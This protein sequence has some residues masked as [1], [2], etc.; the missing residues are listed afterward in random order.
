MHSGL[1][2]GFGIVFFAINIFTRFHEMCWD[3][4]LLGQ[5]FLVGGMFLLVIGAC[6]EVSVRMLRKI[7]DASEP[8]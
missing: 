6:A 1:L 7:G 5:Y 4:L 3:R 2:R 8:R